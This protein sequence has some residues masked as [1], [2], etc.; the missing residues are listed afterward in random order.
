MPKPSPGDPSIL[1]TLDRHGPDRFTGRCTPGRWRQVFGGHLVAQCLLAAA[2]A[3]DTGDAPY[4][5]H[6]CFLGRGD[7]HEPITY[8][9]RV[10]KNGRAFTVVEVLA[11]QGEWTLATATAAWHRPETSGA[12]QAPAPD[13]PVAADCPPVDLDRIGGPSPTY[14]PIEARLA[15]RSEPVDDGSAPWLRLWKRWRHRLPDDPLM[16]ACAV[17]WIS[18]TSMTRTGALPDRDAGRPVQ[19][20]SLDHTLRFHREPR[21]D[22][23]LLT[24]EISPIRVGGRALVRGAIFDEAGL[25]VASTDQE[26]L[27]RTPA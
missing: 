26:C 15:G 20:A 7:T 17:A 18:D 11:G 16:H 4:S 12:H 5:I 14:D 23:W 8:T 10:L 24:D 22:T 2:H 21:A 25:L 19:H 27:M 13:V 6:T 3:C 9:T 1:F